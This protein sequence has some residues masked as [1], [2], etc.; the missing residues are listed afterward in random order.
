MPEETYTGLEPPTAAVRLG[1]LDIAY[2]WDGAATQPYTIRDLLIWHDCQQ[3]YSIDQGHAPQFDGMRVGWC[4]AG[5]G[6]HTL[7]Q[8]DPLTIVASV[9]WPD[10]CGLHGFITNG[11]WTDA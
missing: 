7:V 4:P 5:V 9:Y 2:E 8:V 6:A 11:V 3:R 1:R 10:C